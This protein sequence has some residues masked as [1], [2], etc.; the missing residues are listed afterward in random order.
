MGLK[1]QP[2]DHRHISHQS[3][4]VISCIF[5]ACFFI[6]LAF[7]YI[8]IRRNRA[9][10]I[11][12]SNYSSRHFY[13]TFDSRPGAPP[14]FLDKHFIQPHLSS[15]GS[16]LLLPTNEI[17]PKGL[18]IP[19][20]SPRR[21]SA[22][23]SIQSFLKG[24]EH[25]LDNSIQFSQTLAECPTLHLS[26]NYIHTVERLRIVVDKI[27]GM[28]EGRRPSIYTLRIRVIPKSK[29][30]AYLSKPLITPAMVGRPDFDHLFEYTVSLQR[31]ELARI[32]ATLFARAWSDTLLYG[33]RRYT[34]GA[35]PYAN[36]SIICATGN[37]RPEVD[38]SDLLKEYTEVARAEFVLDTSLLRSNP[39]ALQHLVLPLSLADDEMEEETKETAEEYEE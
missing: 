8:A 13:D 30:S 9:S 25:I 28:K 38:L 34:V 23:K 10:S 15:Y 21:H 36:S 5:T 14:I 12:K 26:I 35:I 29:T 3:I 22:P 37:S 4:I 1:Q 6:L 19:A 31:L 17:H 27:T 11:L 33:R 20:I 24:D 18:K 2:S 16:T 7:I 32:E 39:E